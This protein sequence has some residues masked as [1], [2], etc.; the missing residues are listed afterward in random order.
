MGLGDI[1][2]GVTESETDMHTRQARLAG[3]IQIPMQGGARGSAVEP[4]PAAET[5]HHGRARMR[6]VPGT[7]QSS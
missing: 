6:S 2:L 1:H 5:R 3:S 4:P 7:E